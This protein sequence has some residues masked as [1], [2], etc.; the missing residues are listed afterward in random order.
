[1][2]SSKKRQ[3]PSIVKQSD[4]RSAKSE[5][6]LIDDFQKNLEKLS[7]QPYRSEEDSIYNQISSIMGNRPRF[8]SVQ[9]AVRDMQNRSGLTD[10][11][12]KLNS[13]SQ[14]N[15]KKIA[16]EDS[17]NL[18]VVGILQNQSIKSTIDNIISDNHG[19]MDISQ[20][21]SRAKQIHGTEVSDNVMWDQR[22]LFEYIKKKSDECRRD[23][24]QVNDSNL[25][26][27]PSGKD[28]LDTAD[29]SN[30]DAFHSLNPAIS[31]K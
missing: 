31:G 1:L 7:V 30:T 16:S 29:P 25:G 15:S 3:L 17:R 6:S 27:R 8:S 26:R 13:E 12:K 18:N 10:Y 9:A 14:T 11:L 22:E 28:I 4:W 21:L 20:V 24:G 23:N 2:T 19:A 5:S